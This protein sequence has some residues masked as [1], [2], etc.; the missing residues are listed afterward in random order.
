VSKKSQDEFYK[1]KFKKT[2]N[3]YFC[4]RFLAVLYD[5][6]AAFRVSTTFAC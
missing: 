5:K 4:I 6:L 3:G 2:K 1:E